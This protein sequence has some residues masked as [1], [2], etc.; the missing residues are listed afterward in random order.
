MMSLSLLAG[1]IVVQVKLV[2]PATLTMHDLV[3]AMEFFK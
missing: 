2:V 3:H 1:R